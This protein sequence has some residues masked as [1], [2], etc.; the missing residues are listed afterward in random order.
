MPFNFRDFIRTTFLQITF[1]WLPLQLSIGFFSLVSNF[2][3]RLFK[4]FNCID[5][6]VCLFIKFL[7]NCFVFYSLIMLFS[8][9]SCRFFSLF[10]YI[11]MQLMYN[12][13]K[14]TLC[15]AFGSRFQ[16]FRFERLG[17]LRRNCGVFSSS[18][19]IRIYWIKIYSK[20]SVYWSNIRAIL[21]WS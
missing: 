14:H 9:V 21:M 16:T 13:R 3:L 18:A 6:K 2:S 1:R 8:N 12:D 10:S 5:C 15:K 4:I 11:F 17:S 19:I 7:I 20:R